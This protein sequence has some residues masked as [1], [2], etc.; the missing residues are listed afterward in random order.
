MES[1][2][3]MWTPNFRLHLATAGDNTAGDNKTV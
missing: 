2:I 1:L 3:R